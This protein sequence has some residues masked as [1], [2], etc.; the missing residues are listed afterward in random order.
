MPPPP[1]IVAPELEY[2]FTDRPRLFRF[3]LLLA[4]I[5]IDL[6]FDLGATFIDGEARPAL[7]LLLK[8]RDYRYCLRSHM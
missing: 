5:P 7:K 3:R 8:W 2:P 1:P 4:T 6:D